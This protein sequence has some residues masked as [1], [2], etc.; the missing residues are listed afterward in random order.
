MLN[1]QMITCLAYNCNKSINVMNFNF[2]QIGLKTRL[3]KVYFV[4]EA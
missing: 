3:S 4:N 1:T 2:L